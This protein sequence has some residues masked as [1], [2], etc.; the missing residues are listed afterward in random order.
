[1]PLYEYVCPACAERF[2]QLQ[3]VGASAE[4]VAC[5]RCG[6]GDVER[7]HS[8]FAAATGGRSDSRAEAAGCGRPQ[9]AGGTC[10][11]GWN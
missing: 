6:N 2:E 10:A 11:G 3:R 5:P 8:T 4:S 9:C 7:Q 1:M